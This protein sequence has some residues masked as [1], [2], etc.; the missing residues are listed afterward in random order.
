MAETTILL[1]AFSILG[2]PKLKV[3]TKGGNYDEGGMTVSGGEFVWETDDIILM[4]VTQANADGGVTSDSEITRIIVYDNA[5]DYLNGVEKFVY[6]GASGQNA[7]I[8][9]ATAGVGDNYLRINANVLTSTDPAAPDINELFLVAGTDLSS[10]VENNETL[11]IDQF[12]DNDYNANDTI[13]GGSSEIADGIF[14]GGAGGNDIYVVLCF[15]RGTLIETPDGPRYVETLRA[16]DLVNTLDNGPQPLAWAGGERIAGTGPNA[17]VR[18]A[19]G[20]LGNVRELVVSQNHRMLLHGAKAELMF[21]QP[22]VLVAAKHLVDHQKIRIVE[23]A[24][25]HYFHLLFDHHQIIFAEGCPTESLHLGQEA[26]KTVGAQTRDEII[27]LF[28]EL[29]GRSASG[30]LSRYALK[31]YEAHALRRSA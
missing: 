25:V 27:T 26:L 14:H 9:G 10:V 7:S 12:S 16:G 17:P 5:A 21:G 18:I 6:E 20:V 24:Q 29:A 2:G 3:S 8:R 22:E 11:F 15:A 19:P 31:H 1:N 23:Q 28:P 4:E 30:D 13:D